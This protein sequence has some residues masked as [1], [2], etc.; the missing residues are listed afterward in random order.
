MGDAR[1]A[2]EALVQRVAVFDPVRSVADGRPQNTTPSRAVAVVGIQTHESG[3]RLPASALVAPGV[4]PNRRREDGARSDPLAAVQGGACGRAGLDAL[5]GGQRPP[6][7]ARRAGSLAQP[8]LPR[9]AAHGGRTGRV[10]EAR[11]CL[12]GGGP[13][14]GHAGVAGRRLPDAALVVQVLPLPA[15]GARHPAAQHHVER[16]AHPAR[17]LRRR[18]ASP[19]ARRAAERAACAAVPHARIGCSGLVEQRA[20][21]RR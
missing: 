13:R 14:H 15:D 19:S 11:R 5:G 7:A 9:P 10:D 4:R 16:G 6:S 2:H 3:C 1:R 21:A 12:H 17:V 20:G 8:V 18:A